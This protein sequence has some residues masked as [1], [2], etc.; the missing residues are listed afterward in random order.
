ML[1]SVVKISM[2]S[3]KYFEDYTFILRGSFFRG[4]AVERCNPW[5]H[6]AN[7]HISISQ[8]RVLSLWRHSHDD[9]SRPRWSQSPFS[10]WRNF[11]CDIIWYSAG[12]AHRYG[13]TY[14]GYGHLTA[15][16]I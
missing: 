9:V 12:H 2:M 4:H 11:H 16:N 14:V 10:L 1:N 7:R 5:S 6:V 15:F 8:L 3:A 13:Q